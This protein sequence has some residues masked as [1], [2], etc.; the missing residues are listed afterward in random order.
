MG[1]VTIVEEFPSQ[2]K[3]QKYVKLYKE[4]AGDLIDS[5]CQK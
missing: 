4:R 1:R 2:T 5:S 3:A